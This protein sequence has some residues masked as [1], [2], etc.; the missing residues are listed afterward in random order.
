MNWQNTEW[1][2]GVTLKQ[3][4]GAPPGSFY[5]DFPDNGGHVNCILS[6]RPA[7]RLGQTITARYF[8]H[9]LQ[10]IPSIKGFGNDPGLPSNF[11]PMLTSGGSLDNRWYPTGIDCGFLERMDAPLSYAIPIAA[12]FWQDV[13]GRPAAQHLGAFRNVV[14]HSGSLCLVFG[15]HNY[16][17]HG[18]Y[19]VNGKA[20]LGIWSVVVS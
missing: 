5:F 3:W 7:Y 8:L 15:W 13:N 19:C 12:Q 17:A 14:E 4:Q 10:G 2:S 18:L 16:F 6:N 20:R 11:R 1:N 9:P